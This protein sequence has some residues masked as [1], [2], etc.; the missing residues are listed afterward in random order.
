MRFGRDPEAI[1]WAERLPVG[2]YEE[3]LRGGLEPG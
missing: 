2:D 1:E 3:L